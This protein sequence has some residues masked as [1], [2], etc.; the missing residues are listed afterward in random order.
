MPAGVLGHGSR[1]RQLV[2]HASAREHEQLAAILWAV[3]ERCARAAQAAARHRVAGQAPA[4][5]GAHNG[6]T[7]VGLR[8]HAAWVEVLRDAGEPADTEA[9][10]PAKLTA[11]YVQQAVQ[12][13]ALMAQISARAA[14]FVG[15]HG[16]LIDAAP[17]ELLGPLDLQS[18]P[19]PRPCEAGRALETGRGDEVLA[20][21]AQLARRG[22]RLMASVPAGCSGCAWGSCGLDAEGYRCSGCE[23]GRLRVRVS[24]AGEQSEQLGHRPRPRR[25]HVGGLQLKGLA[26][27]ARRR[28][29]SSQSEPSGVMLR[30]P[31][32]ARSTGRM[33]AVARATRSAPATTAAA[34]TWRSFSA[35]GI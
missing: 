17:F 10:R 31:T 21:L 4:A 18:G 35:F 11:I 24:T 15:R 7:G 8:A 14:E 32:C 16:P 25:S 33:P 30:L 5:R 34:R 29:S 20:V 12:V 28:R 9:F 26:H 13:A 22:L 2:R 19:P 1:S 27:D 6:R 3:R 23:F